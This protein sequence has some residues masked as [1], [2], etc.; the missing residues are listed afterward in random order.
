[1]SARLAPFALLLAFTPTF[2]QAPEDDPFA[3]LDAEL[4]AQFQATDAELEERFLALDAALKA[5]FE[6]AEGEIAD[7]WG[8]EEVELP[9]KKI[10]V[11][12]SDD[13][14]TRRR[15]D[16]ERGEI[17]IERLIDPEDVSTG[18]IAADAT[19]ATQALK[20]ATSRDLAERDLVVKYAREQL[21]EEGIEFERHDPETDDRVL[22]PVVLDLPEP[23]SIAPLLDTA[24]A[25][26]KAQQGDISAESRKLPNGKQ[27]VAVRVPLK[28]GYESTLA[29][30]FEDAVLAQAERF[31]VDPSLVYAVI[32]TESSF[33][34]RARSPVPA[35]GLMQ[36]VPRSG[37]IDAYNHVYGEKVLLDPEYLYDARQNIE[38]GAAYLNLLFSR[39]LRL[40]QNPESRWICAIAAY[41]TGAGNV[42][43]AFTGKTN[44]GE[45]AQ[46]I[47]GMTPE[48]I[49][50]HLREHLPY[51]ETR[52]YIQKVRDARKGFRAIDVNEAAAL[53]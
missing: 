52:N 14:Q 1:M 31:D 51:E 42:A 40:I 17:I 12:Y 36:L 9:S 33:N 44:V 11:D 21:A 22:S 15:I 45:A 3:A 39:Y 5:A 20:N 6:R 23:G 46:I 34:P 25:K 16:F 49:F 27:T 2:A 38:L 43:R 35:F 28:Q 24:I 30:R 37:G 13:M 18:Q 26:G 47:N 53:D 10:W 29:A 50:E 32:Q 4:E 41:N 19:I 48:E 7:E 8:D